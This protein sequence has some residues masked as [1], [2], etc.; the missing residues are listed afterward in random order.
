VKE[1]TPF[2]QLGAEDQK[3]AIDVGVC[4]TVLGTRVPSCGK[5]LFDFVATE[6]VSSYKLPP[7]MGKYAL[8][9]MGRSLFDSDWTFTVEKKG[10]AL[11]TRFERTGSNDGNAP[12]QTSPIIH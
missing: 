3:A 5:P 7:N 12:L 6:F 8:R 1:E 4:V 11:V 2:E 9:Q 10:D